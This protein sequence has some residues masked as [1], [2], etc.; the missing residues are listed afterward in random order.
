MYSGFAECEFQAIDE[1]SNEHFY[2]GM[3]TN[4]HLPGG[5][6]LLLLIMDNDER[7]ANRTTLFL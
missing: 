3:A 4:I 7:V 6:R 5:D 2:D 1:D